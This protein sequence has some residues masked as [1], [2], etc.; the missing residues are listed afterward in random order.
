MQSRWGKAGVGE[1]HSR[2]MFQLS[3]AG[4]STARV[5]FRVRNVVSS[6]VNLNSSRVDR[7]VITKAV[8]PA[9]VHFEQS[10]F[11]SLLCAYI[12]TSYD[13]YLLCKSYLGRTR[14]IQPVL[15]D[16]D[17]LKIPCYA[18][19]FCKTSERKDPLQHG[20]PELSTAPAL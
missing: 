16:F 7:I 1:N 9:A 15:L 13:H 17:E 3:T 12:I 20:R 8:I 10:D 18:M 4:S 11:S 14:V 2:P 5:A 6:M 19:L